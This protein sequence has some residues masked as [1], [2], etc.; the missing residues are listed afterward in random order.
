PRCTECHTTF[1]PSDSAVDHPS[2]ELRA[3]AWREAPAR[4]DV[5][6][7][8]L[9]LDARG[10]ITTFVEGMTIT[11]EGLATPIRRELWAPLDPH[12]TGPSRACASC[13]A[14]I[15]VDRLFPASGET[16]RTNA[17][18]LDADARERVTRVAEC[19]PCHATWGD[20]IW[21]DLDAS[22]GRMRPE[23]QRP[24]EPRP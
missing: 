8:A 15:L 5:G 16:T 12:T 14:P 20:V 11:I 17:R 23:C 1:A 4:F 6:L 3:G 22:R 18:L 2:G 13:H 19:L 10:R 21:R 9:A 24:S 7:P